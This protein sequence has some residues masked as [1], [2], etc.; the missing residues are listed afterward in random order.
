MDVAQQC[1]NRMLLT[2]PTL[3][4]EVVA[5]HFSNWAFTMMSGRDQEGDPM[6]ALIMDPMAAGVGARSYKDGVDSGGSVCCPRAKTPMVEVNE[7]LYP[8]LYLYRREARDGGG[9][10]R[11]RG[12][13]GIEYAFALH[14]AP[15]PM[16]HLMQTW[17]V[18]LPV[19]GGVGGGYPGTTIEYVINADSSIKQVFE[20]GKMPADI[21]DVPGTVEYPD[22]KGNA[23]QGLDDVYYTIATGSGG[24]GD[25][26][27]RDPEKV[28]ED[29]VN[30]YVSTAAAAAIYGVALAG[31]ALDE[32]ETAKLRERLRAERAECAIGEGTA[33][34]PKPAAAGERLP[35]SEALAL[36]PTE[37]G[38]GSGRVVV[39]D[40]CDCALCDADDNYKDHSRQRFSPVAE[41]PNG[42]DPA[43][44]GMEMTAELRQ[45]FCPSCAV[46]FET[47]VAV[48]GDPVLREIEMGG[49][50]D[51]AAA[52]GIDGRA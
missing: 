7:S 39:C 47:E 40:R 45:Y 37:A 28:A 1:V 24:F 8:L 27:E 31:E 11:Y 46:L 17:G 10:G 19:T 18:T 15:E 34:P 21:H 35:M 48:V 50:R 3:R 26:L 14:D 23:V 52:L 44:Y 51:R 12:G 20:E 5:D 16:K 41:L 42:V 29:V 32:A 13:V 38:A 2:H 43:R 6:V 36:A 22:F 4:K 33:E 9:A 25:P 49:V 30:G